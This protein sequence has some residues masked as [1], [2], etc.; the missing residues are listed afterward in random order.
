MIKNI[1]YAWCIVM[2]VA[3]TACS[4]GSLTS[5]DELNST[6]YDPESTGNEAID[7]QINA[8]YKKYGSKILY[9]FPASDLY[10]GWSNSDIKWYV[11]VKQE[12]SETY[13]ER[14]VSFLENDA[15]NEYRLHSQKSFFHT[16]SSW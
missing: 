13:I 14:M 12:G 4:E 15:L 6:I 3:I 9:D 5:I 1:L 16:E 8:F 10:F 11:P 7:N 2:T